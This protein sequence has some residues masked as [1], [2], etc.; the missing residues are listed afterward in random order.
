MVRNQLMPARIVHEGVLDAFLKTERN[1]FVPQKFQSVA[2]SDAMIPLE[3]KRTYL[4]PEITARLLQQAKPAPHMKALVIE[5]ATGF[6]VA[7][8]SHLVKQVTGTESHEPL[9]RQA[10][11]ALS[12][13]PKSK[14]TL[15]HQSPYQLETSSPVDLIGL[16]GAVEESCLTTFFPLLVPGG[17][18][19]CGLNTTIGEAVLYEKTQKGNIGKRVLFETKMPLIPSCCTHN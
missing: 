7:L 17:R 8:L 16:F 18:L 3:C 14:V 6:E 11:Q 2:Y 1:L 9:I 4:T 15:C 5:C 19:L 12:L 13:Y 10:Q